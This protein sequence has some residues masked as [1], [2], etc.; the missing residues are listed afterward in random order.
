MA[1]P[2]EA[3]H[4]QTPPRMAEAAW[5]RLLRVARAV[6]REIEGDR[7]HSAHRHQVYTPKRMRMRNTKS[8]SLSSLERARI[9]LTRF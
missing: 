6:S 9:R 8:A 5:P 7:L 2:L 3:I 1:Q 4:H